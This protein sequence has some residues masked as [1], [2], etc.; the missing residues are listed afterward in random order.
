MHILDD[1]YNETIIPTDGS[2][3]DVY[4]NQRIRKPVYW[5][6]APSNVRRC[7][8]FLRNRSSSNY[9][10]YDESIATLLEVIVN[11]LIY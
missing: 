1:Q 4:L 5:S 7:S 2:R 11:F 10:P 6:D 9:I 8:W 3:F